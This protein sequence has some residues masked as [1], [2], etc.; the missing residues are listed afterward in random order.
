[1]LPTYL[2]SSVTNPGEEDQ[3]FTCECGSL[4]TSI[5]KLID[6]AEAAA[7]DIDITIEQTIV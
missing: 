5:D 6:E 3:I 1:M 2:V 7:N 4:I